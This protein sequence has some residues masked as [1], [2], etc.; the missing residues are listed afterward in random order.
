LG[1]THFDHEIV[2]LR[3]AP[4][5][6][7]FDARIGERTTNVWMRTESPLTPNADA[8]L[9]ATAMPAM[10]HGG[11]LGMTDPVSPRMLRG[12]REFQ[13][14]QRAWSLDWPFGVPLEAVDVV[15]PTRDP[16]S[17]TPGDRVAAF[18][19]GG[20]DSWGTL[21]E[22]PDVTDLIFIRGFDLAY[23][24]PHAR[25]AD[26]VEERLRAAAGEMERPLHVVTTNLREATGG[27][28][29]W[30]LYY[31]CALT[32]VALFLGPLFNRVLIAS[33]ADYEV[34]GRWGT[35]W[36]VDQLWSTE[37][38]EIVDDGGRHSRMDRLRRLA[39]NPVACRSLRV[40]WENPDRTYNC[41]R[42]QKCLMTLIPLEAIGARERVTTFP[43]ELD[44]D[45]KGLAQLVIPNPVSLSYWEDMLDAAREAKRGDLEAALAPVVAKSKAGLGLP[46]VGGGRGRR[47]RQ[48]PRKELWFP[49][50]RGIPPS[51]LP[52]RPPRLSPRQTRLHSSSAATT[53]PVTTATC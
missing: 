16:E 37:D 6:L 40:C 50:K 22:N 24:G 31:G 39:E 20:V 51:T 38:L 29:P 3:T 11:V 27:H 26:E 8:A 36:L 1:T 5:E 21:L 28:V 43:P 17:H 30:D 2:N 14:I 7:S 23:A 19:S 45:P 46:A 4:G 32:S 41:G 47:P 13:A 53:G 49:S 33:D 48:P 9:A 52:R 35:N 12:Q 10:R 15:A 25:L 18:F 34:Q 44:L 42:C